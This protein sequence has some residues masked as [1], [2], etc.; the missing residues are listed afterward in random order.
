MIEYKPM[1]CSTRPGSDSGPGRPDKRRMYGAQTSAD[2]TTASPG[3]SEK[4]SVLAERL[5]QKKGLFHA[6]DG[7]D[8][9]EF[10]NETMY[11]LSWVVDV[12]HYEEGASGTVVGRVEDLKF[13]YL[14]LLKAHG[15]NVCHFRLRDLFS[16][17]N[18]P[19]VEDGTQVPW[20]K[21]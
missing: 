11:S 2:S 16:I 9:K 21:R 20:Y 10:G 13:L 3:S 15:R 14:A 1:K 6:A 7:N 8:C 17:G 4:V 19:V 5:E 18:Y 12:G